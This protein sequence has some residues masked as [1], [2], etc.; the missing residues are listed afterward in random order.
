[1]CLLITVHN[2]TTRCSIV[3]QKPQ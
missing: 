3:S 2:A 1:M